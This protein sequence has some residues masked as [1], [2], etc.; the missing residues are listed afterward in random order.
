M[1]AA[2]PRRFRQVDTVAKF[3]SSRRRQLFFAPRGNTLNLR[4]LPSINAA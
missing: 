3:V 1:P 4:T 2:V